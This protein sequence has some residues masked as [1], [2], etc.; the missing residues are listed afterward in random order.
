MVTY[1]IS[2]CYAHNPLAA[3]ETT[4]KLPCHL[5]EGNLL[6]SGAFRV[7]ALKF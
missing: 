3:P 2:T 1:M 7:S 4:L 5:L 6:L